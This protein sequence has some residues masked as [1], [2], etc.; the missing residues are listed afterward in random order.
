M[1]NQPIFKKKV[2]RLQEY[3]SK[4][5]PYVALDTD[6]LLKNEEKRAAME[7]WFQLMVDEAVD[8]NA[9]LAYQIGGKVADSYKSSFHELVSLSVFDGSFAEKIGD[10]AKVR[11]QMTHDYEK[12]Q[13][14]ELIESMKK[15]F[16]LYTEY[17]RIIVS[18]FLSTELS[19]S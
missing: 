3:I 11:N 15:Y 8:I 19:D 18:K 16:E 9:F 7:R 5:A 10:S 1:Q 17:V 13:Y 4:L 6:E 12:M 2:D 14:A